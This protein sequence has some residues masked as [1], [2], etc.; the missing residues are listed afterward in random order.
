MTQFDSGGKIQYFDWGTTLWYVDPSNLERGRLCA[1]IVTFNPYT[2]EELHVHS[3]NEQVI[4]VISGSGKQRIGTRECDIYPRDIHHVPPHSQ[5]QIINTGSEELKLFIVYTPAGFQ[6]PMKAPAAAPLNGDGADIK[7]F[8]DYQALGDILS[9]FSD[10]IGMGL[11]I[12]DY[13]GELIMRTRNYPDFCNLLS[14]NSSSNYCTSKIQEACRQIDCFDKPYLFKCCNDIMSIIIPIYSGNQVFGYIIC[15]QVFL[16]KVDEGVAR[17]NMKYLSGRFHIP[18][19]QLL[20]LYSQIRLELKNRLYLSAEAMRTVASCITDMVAS[21]K[22][23]KELDSSKMSIIEEQ[24]A[25][26]KLEK[27]LR[28]ADLK[29]LQSQIQPHFLFNTLNTIAQMAYVDGAERVAN[30]VWNL[31]DLLRYTLKKNEQLVPLSEELKI[32]NSYLQIQLSRFGDRLKIDLD[33]QEAL[34]NFLIPSMLLQPLAENAIIHGFEGEVRQGNIKITIGAVENYIHCTI[35]DDGIGFDP[36]N[37]KDSPH[38]C[39]NI[40]LSSVKN[41]LQYYF[42]NNY[43]FEI[44]SKPQAGTTVSLSF[45]KTGDTHH[46]GN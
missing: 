13:N 3:N 45:P 1:G 11:S 42:N 28:E 2:V 10:V 9:K 33:V 36:A 44:K 26:A 16:K 32:L 19:A 6:V 4:Y 25:K 43:T 35:Q 15:G 5:H 29:L 14:D 17:K 20:R 34:E 18:E 40:G 30:L 22:R 7:A 23:Q 41:R 12:L 37:K 31:S 46:A 21:A 38:G 24:I 27:A 8:I 39:N